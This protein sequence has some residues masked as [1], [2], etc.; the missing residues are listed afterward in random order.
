MLSQRQNDSAPHL[1]DTGPRAPRRSGSRPCDSIA[2]IL[3]CT[4]GEASAHPPDFGGKAFPARTPQ[5]V[6]PIPYAAARCPVR[7]SSPAAARTAGRVAGRRRDHGTDIYRASIIK[8]ECGKRTGSIR[9]FSQ[10][11]LPSK[12][13]A[14]GSALAADSVSGLFFFVFLYYHVFGGMSTT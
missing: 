6:R 10:M 7:R 14:S 3:Y 12:R 8:A 2:Y 11:P 9:L 13:H 4:S 1:K 5:D